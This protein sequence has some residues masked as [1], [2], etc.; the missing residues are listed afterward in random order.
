M[1]RAPGPDDSAAR[2]EP[3]GEEPRRTLRLRPEAEAEIRAA[4]EDVVAGRTVELSEA[5]LAEW[6]RT[7]ELPASVEVRFAALG[8]SEPRS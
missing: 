1:Q 4:L 5:E 8:C 6:E 7:G 2:F 3:E